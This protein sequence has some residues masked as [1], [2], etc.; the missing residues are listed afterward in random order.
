MPTSNGQVS[1]R[2]IRQKAIKTL[3]IVDES[4]ATAKLANLAV[5]VAK[6][7]TVVD[8]EWVNP[9]F[10]QNVTINTT[11]TVHNTL[12]IDVPS[13]AG[14]MALSTTADLQATITSDTTFYFW[15]TIDS[16]STEP[17]G[18]NTHEL[19]AT[20]T[21]HLQQTR[22]WESTV[23]P[24]STITV[25]FWIKTASGSNSSNIV[26]LDALALFAR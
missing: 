14:I 19:A 2:D 20:G 1:S 15:T 16:P 7:E 10:E 12:D 4:I 21:R 26:R 22:Y 17:S 8:W 25:E 6:N 24:G 18:A 13:W 3:H 23:T 5:T 9:N 11:W